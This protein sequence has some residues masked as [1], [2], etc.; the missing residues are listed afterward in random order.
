VDAEV[1]IG[2]HWRAADDEAVSILFGKEQLRLEFYDVESLERLREV[3]DQAARQLR[4]VIDAS[5]RADDAG[6]AAAEQPAD[7]GGRG[8][9]T[10]LVGPARGAR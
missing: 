3:A 4:A 10:G 2:L 1:Q 6:V 7:V 5:V 8:E 9:V